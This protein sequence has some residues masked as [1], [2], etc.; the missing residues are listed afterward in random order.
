LDVEID[1]DGQEIR[2]HRLGGGYA[3]PSREVDATGDPLAL[4]RIVVSASSKSALSRIAL[5]VHL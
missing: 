3:K 1:S 5:Q 4:T 2:A